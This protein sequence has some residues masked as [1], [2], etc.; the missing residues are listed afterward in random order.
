MNFGGIGAA[1]AMAVADASKTLAT[2]TADSRANSTSRGGAANATST[3]L[4]AHKQQAYALSTAT[5]T[6]GTAKSVAT[7]SGQF[8]GSLTSTSLAPVNSSSSI[9]ESNTNIGGPIH[10]A[11]TAAASTAS[12]AYASGLVNFSNLGT[13]VSAG[14]NNPAMI[15]FGSGTL[16]AHYTS[17]STGAQTYTGSIAWIIDPAGAGLPTN[18]HIDLGL[19]DSLGSG[20]GFSKLA[21]SVIENGD[22]L[23]SQSFTSLAA[24][25]AY[26]SDQFLDLGAWT[27]YGSPIDLTVNLSVTLATLGDGYGVDFM[28]GDPPPSSVPEPNILALFGVGWWGAS[29]CFCR[30]K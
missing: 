19:V 27:R 20:G 24:A 7:T 9:A 23:L 30:R 25:N 18:G 14:F 12:Y 4:A 5:G 16:G 10:S 3:A 8:V 1:T 15:T 21:F 22:S 17:D 29:R 26:F 28:L 2:G 13:H 11:S 6:S